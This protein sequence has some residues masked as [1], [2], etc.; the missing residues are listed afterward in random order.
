[1]IYT[2]DQLRNHL[3]GDTVNEKEEGQKI[4]Y[5][6]FLSYHNRKRIVAAKTI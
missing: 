2:K 6:Y 5:D 1:M 3:R 4:N